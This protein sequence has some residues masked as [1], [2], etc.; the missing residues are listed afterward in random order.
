MI[1]GNK[2]PMDNPEYIPKQREQIGM[3]LPLSLKHLSGRWW[4]IYFVQEL[5]G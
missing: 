2:K 1:T 5:F 3:G 4:Q